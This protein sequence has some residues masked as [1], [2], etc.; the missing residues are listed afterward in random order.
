MSDIFIFIRIIGPSPC[1]GHHDTHYIFYQINPKSS[2]QKCERDQ[3]EGCVQV[4]GVTR[5]YQYLV[6]MGRNMNVFGARCGLCDPI[7]T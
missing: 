1:V 5:I 6:L 2:D 4:C 3:N 7:A